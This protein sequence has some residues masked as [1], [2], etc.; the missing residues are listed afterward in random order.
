[1]SIIV[2]FYFF[3]SVIFAPFLV[4]S[5]DFFIH[6]TQDCCTV[7]EGIIWLPEF[8]YSTLNDMVDWD[9]ELTVEIY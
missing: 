3:V 5:Y 9:Q 7:T 6:P 8:E 4:K 1:M 2:L